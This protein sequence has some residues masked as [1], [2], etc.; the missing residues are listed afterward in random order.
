MGQQLLLRLRPGSAAA[1]GLLLAGLLSLWA[2]PVTAAGQGLRA[3]KI[4]PEGPNQ[5]LPS[6]FPA[7]DD[8]I[9]W[10]GRVLRDEGLYRCVPWL[11]RIDWIEVIGWVD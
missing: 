5:L 11:G 9:Q 8:R 1:L 4:Q 7:T 3:V 2:V 10:T 6:F